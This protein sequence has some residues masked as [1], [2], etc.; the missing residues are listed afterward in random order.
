MYVVFSEWHQ[1]A[2]SMESLT[3]DKE[4]SEV[5]LAVQYAFLVTFYED[6]TLLF[7][8]QYILIF[9]ASNLLVFAR[10]KP[11]TMDRCYSSWIVKILVGMYEWNR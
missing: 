3:N 10:G 4:D 6:D 1:K 11:P 7:L 9:Y 5:I 8:L 2:G